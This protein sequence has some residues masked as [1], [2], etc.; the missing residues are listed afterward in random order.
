MKPSL[1]IAAFRATLLASRWPTIPVRSV[2]SSSSSSSISSNNIIGGGGGG[3]LIGINNYVLH[4]R[5]FH[6]SA[7]LAHNPRESKESRKSRDTDH[8]H[9][10]DHDHD[11]EKDVVEVHIHV[12]HHNKNFKFEVAEGETLMDLVLKEGEVLGEYF[13]C[14][15]GGIAACSTCH[16]YLDNESYGKL[17]VP[18]EFELDMIDLAY[19][20]KDTSRLGCQVQFNKSINGVK[21]TVPKG[22]NNLH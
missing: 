4:Q 5:C 19:A 13:E 17:G 10:H 12:L 11:H 16:V 18:E 7:T 9:D 8:G 22:V 15:C 2:L 14:A 20:P 3:G 1:L 21:L 6:Q